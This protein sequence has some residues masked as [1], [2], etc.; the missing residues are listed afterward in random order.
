M[1]KDAQ[2]IFPYTAGKQRNF[3]NLL[4]ITKIIRWTE[5]C[6]NTLFA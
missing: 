6:V 4:L 5:L 1:M 3:L 2:E